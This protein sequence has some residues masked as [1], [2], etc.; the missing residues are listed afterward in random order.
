MGITIYDNNVLRDGSLRNVRR[1]GKAVGYEMLTR[2]TYYRGIPLN[3]VHNIE[4]EVNDRPVPR[5]NIRFS[6]DGEQY[7]TLDI[8]TTLT[9]YKWKYD[10]H[11]YVF[12]KQDGGLSG[13]QHK[14]K[15]TQIVS[16]AYIP[17]PFSK[18]EIKTMTV[19]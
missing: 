7:L 4:V 12:V 19:Q 16:V 2:I 17:M 8:M 14:V 5:E 13:G 6:L 18:S 3:I 10:Q 9:A 1:D 15:L 11:G